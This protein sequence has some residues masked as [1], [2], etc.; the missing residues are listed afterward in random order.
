MSIPGPLRARLD[1]ALARDD[2]EEVIRLARETL[3]AMREFARELDSPRVMAS[4]D[5]MEAAARDLE[6][7][8][9]DRQEQHGSME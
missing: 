1:Q 4:F 9:N 8:V 5:Q 7:K 3:P 2:F 6:T